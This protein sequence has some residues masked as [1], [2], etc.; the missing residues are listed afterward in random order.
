[1][2]RAQVGKEQGAFQAGDHGLIINPL[3]R[4]CDSFNNLEFFAGTEC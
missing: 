2:D 1:M 3:T 4:L